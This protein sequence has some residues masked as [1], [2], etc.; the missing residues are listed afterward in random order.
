MKRPI[1]ILLAVALVVTA[2]SSKKK[3]PAFY[4][5]SETESDSI[6]EGGIDGYDSCYEYE[7]ETIR[8]GF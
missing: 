7:E 8:V 2:C 1:Y 5:S 6:Y 3:N 4:G